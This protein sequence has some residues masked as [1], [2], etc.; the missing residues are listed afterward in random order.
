MHTNEKRIED[1]LLN[2]D[3]TNRTILDNTFDAIVSIDING[4]ILDWNRRAESIFGWQADEVIGKKLTETII[5]KQ[6]RSDHTQGMQ[7]FLST[8]KSR[9]LNQQ[10]ELSA[11]HRAGNEFPIEISINPS[12]LNDQL[13]FT[14][15]IRDITERKNALKQARLRTEEYKVLHE[16]AQAL[17]DSDSMET[18]LQEALEAISRSKELHV[19]NK[20]GIFL[21]DEEK[22]VLH[23][24]VKLGKFPDDF[25]KN[26]TEIPFYNIPYGRCLTSGDIVINDWCMFHPQQSGP[27]GD[28]TQYGSYIVPLKSRNDT[29]GV[30]FLYTPETPPCYEGSQEILLSIAALMGNAIKHRQY[31]RKIQQQNKKLKEF[32]TLKNKFLGIASHDLRNPLYSILSYSNILIDGSMGELNKRQQETLGKIIH[33]SEFMRSLLNNL[34]D[35]SKIESGQITLEKIPQDINSIVL[36]QVEM[37]QLLANRK[38]I[39]LDFEQNDF[40]QLTVDKCA[41][42]QVIDNLI[43][44]AIKF[45]PKD[46]RVLIKTENSNNHFRFS[47]KDEGP[48]ISE[49][50]RKLVFG[51]FQTL[52]NKPTGGE[53]ATG[54]GLAI[55]KKLVHLHGG[56]VGLE[57]TLGN[58][59]TFYF[60]LPLQ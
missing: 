50:D 32:N 42:N 11:M 38:N 44:N 36:C 31:E 9:V 57:S 24:S 60:E 59:S 35:I 21:A 7:R 46:S 37:S 51:E 58:G 10:L 20:A 1:M 27:F 39:Q 19:E 52:S 3:E 56:K 2:V 14:G 16:V 29:V 40:P 6:Y 54:L 25:L 55:S 47:I 5:P 45:S 8:G 23:L 34:L 49:Q 18:M 15:I 22:K 28:E 33:S 48:G 30:L 26:Q 41:M 17:Q 53:K 4:F 43:S 13:I 12:R